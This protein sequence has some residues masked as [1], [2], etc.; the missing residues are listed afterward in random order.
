M[1]STKF[2]ITIPNA[3]NINHLVVFMTGACPLPEG[4]AGAGWSCLWPCALVYLP[5]IFP[6]VVYFSFPDPLAP[7]TWNYLGYISNQKPSA[8]FKITKLKRMN[9][10]NGGVP[11]GGFAFSQPIVSH[12]AQIGISVESANTVLQLASDPSVNAESGTTSQLSKFEEFTNK[13]AE[14]LYN[15]CSSFSNNAVNF[16]SNPSMANQQFIPMATINEWFVRFM[17]NLRENPNFWRA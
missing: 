6:S 16:A 2:L 3:D 9:A 1:E 4:T 17:R 15:Y 8:I 11:M 12:V 13:A 5:I 14:N 7:P 10:V